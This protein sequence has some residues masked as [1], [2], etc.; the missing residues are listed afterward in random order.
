MS[1][2]DSLVESVATFRGV[3]T[4]DE[5]AALQASLSDPLPD[6]GAVI[7]FT[8]SL[9]RANARRKGPSI[10]SRLY[11]IIESFQTF[12]AM[13]ET[14]VLTYMQILSNF[15]SYFQEFSKVLIKVERIR[16]M[17]EEYKTLFPDSEELQKAVCELHASILRCCTQLISIVRRAW[18]VHLL[19][20]VFQSLP[21]EMRTSTDAMFDAVEVVKEQISMAKTRAQVHEYKQQMGKRRELLDGLSKYDYVTAFQQARQKRFKGTGEWIVSAP[22]FI[23][24]RKRPTSGIITLTGKIGSGKTI[25]SAAVIDSIFEKDGTSLPVMF[26]FVR[27]DEPKSMDA[28]TI[29]RSLI[30]QNLQP[31]SMT[32]EITNSLANAAKSLYS[33]ESLRTLLERKLISQQETCVVIDALDEC[34]HSHQRKILQALLSA[35]SLPSINLKL[36]ISSRGNLSGLFQIRQEKPQILFGISTS[37]DAAAHDIEVYIEDALETKVTEGEL[38]FEDPGIKDEIRTEL[39]KGAQGM[40]LWVALEIE[41]VCYQCND[42]AIRSVLR[43]LPKNLTET[44]DRALQRIRARHKNQEAIAQK[45]L[46]VV[47]AAKRPLKL[48]E[49]RIAISI[50]INQSHSRPGQLVNNIDL[51]AQWCEN[52][53]YVDDSTN[54]VQFV[55]HSALKYI[56]EPS[57]LADITHFHR[58]LDDCHHELGEI[59]VTYLNLNDFRTTMIK[60]PKPLP[61]MDPNAIQRVALNASSV[62]NS[63]VKG[64]ETL[65][66]GSPIRQNVPV[67][68]ASVARLERYR[69]QPA[70]VVTTESGGA[71]NFDIGRLLDY[72]AEFWIHHTSSFQS[73]KTHEAIWETWHFMISGAHDLAKT[74]WT[75]EDYAQKSAVAVSWAKNVEHVAL[76]ERFFFAENYPA[77]Y[78]AVDVLS[79]FVN[80]TSKRLLARL[81]SR[82]SHSDS[83]DCYGRAIA[84]GLIASPAVL[85][86]EVSCQ[87]GSSRDGLLPDLCQS[88]TLGTYQPNPAGPNFS[89]LA[90]LSAAWYDIRITLQRLLYYAP[91]WLHNPTAMG[92]SALHLAAEA[93]NVTATKLLLQEG[94]EFRA[95]TK[96]EIGK[97]TPLQIA[98]D[99]GHGIVMKILI[100]WGKEHKDRPP[101]SDVP[102]WKGRRNTIRSNRWGKYPPEAERYLD[103]QEMISGTKVPRVRADDKHPTALPHILKANGLDW[104]DRAKFS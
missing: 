69:N 43:D 29:L 76:L 79:L 101:L 6:V 15:T 90:F 30:R 25:L 68:T 100:D 62:K 92:K 27:F 55:H 81:I 102:E 93:G 3:L 70:A 95:L 42:E 7:A 38:A 61:I 48:A 89:E 85:F 98:M 14:T 5:N 12:S 31:E 83:I 36:F 9:D 104:E 20:A 99:R 72:A 80:M 17:F 86:K 97:K 75:E 91:P 58:P 46:H 1:V 74:P 33:P 16:P 52:L 96:P 65:R 84:R 41:D 10:A 39:S 53:L 94:F 64:L 19:H 45:A 59:C 26:H 35:I 63:V 78:D 8:A 57:S 21:S 87:C 4:S 88:A 73:G 51:V 71:Q 11:S 23:D 47:A 40:F 77:E 82:L 103:L 32:E 22:Q 67:H 2:A 49:L 37:S 34:Q 24:W 50:E 54:T 56:L 13:V 60:R 66:S 44:F 28:E 18:P